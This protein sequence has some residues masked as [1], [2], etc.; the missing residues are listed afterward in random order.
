MNELNSLFDWPSIA[1]VNRNVARPDLWRTLYLYRDGMFIRWKSEFVWLP[2]G[3][4][5]V[6]QWIPDTGS[7]A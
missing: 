2:A 1:D 6:N 7:A 3:W 4:L 5:V